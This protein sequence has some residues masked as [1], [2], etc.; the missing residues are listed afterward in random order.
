LRALILTAGLGT[1]LR[2]LTYVRAKAAVP[3]NGIPIVRRVISWLVQ[4]SIVDLVLNLHHHPAS[5]AAV[6]GDG[7]DLGA[8][9][10]YSWENPILGS[11][12]GPRHALPLLLEGHSDA[13]PFVVVNGDTLTDLRLADMRDTHRRSGAP[14]TMALT[15]NP[16]PDTYGGVMVERGYVTGFSRRGAARESF[17]FVGIQIAEARAF[18]DVADG[19]PAETVMQVYPQLIRDNP[20]AIAAHVVEAAF[21]DVG[22]PADYLQTSMDLA[23]VEGD[24]LVGSKGVTIDPSAE[25]LRTAVWDDVTV[26]AGAR[27]EDCIVCDGAKVPARASYRRCAIVAYE[28]QALR[29]DERVEGTLLIKSFS[30]PQ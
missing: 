29:D 14:V 28:G 4:E 12:G 9:V 19:V 11:A 25:L 24:Q 27:L 23:A 1:R 8:R 7:Q 5:I 13:D 2:P 26:A 22:T 20:R 30:F 6:V 16:R 17:H 18:A 15:P 3:I 10:R 21:R